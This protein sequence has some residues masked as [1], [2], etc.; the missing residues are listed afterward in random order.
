MEFRASNF[1]LARVIVLLMVAAIFVLALAFSIVFFI[2][3]NRAEQSAL[4]NSVQIKADY[5]GELILPTLMF[6]DRLAAEESISLAKSDDLLY[7]VL[8]EDAKGRKFAEFDRPNQGDRS[9]NPVK[10]VKLLF[11]GEQYLGSITVYHSN[12]IAGTLFKRYSTLLAIMTIVGVVV[13]LLLVWFVQHYIGGA[14]VQ[15]VSLTNTITVGE[16]FGKRL[17]VAGF[18]EIESLNDAL[19]KMLDALQL[20]DKKLSAQT[21]ELDVRANFDELTK[22]PNRYKLYE[23]LDGLL[24]EAKNSKQKLA[25]LS[26]DL[27][28][29]KLVNDSLGHQA[30]D[31]LLTIIAERVTKVLFKKHVFARWGGDEFVIAVPHLKNRLEAEELARAVIEAMSQPMKIQSHPIQVTAS[32]GIA[33]YPDHANNREALLSCAD[34]GMYTSKNAGAN[35]FSVYEEKAAVAASRLDIEN[36]LRVAVAKGLFEVRYQP[37][38]NAQTKTIVGLE[39][40]TRW[41]DKQLGVVQPSAFI[42]IAEELG[43]IHELTNI[44]LKQVAKDFDVWSSKGLQTVPVSVNISPSTILLPRFQTHLATALGNSCLGWTDLVLEVTEEVALQRSDDV[45]RA[46]QTLMDKGVNIALDDFGTRFSTLEHLAQLPVNI[47]KIDGVFVRSM[48]DKFGRNIRIIQSIIDLAHQLGLSVTAECV[49]TEEQLVQLREMGCDRVQ[50][51]LFYPALRP[52]ECD[53]LL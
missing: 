31:Q 27:D 46:L 18:K 51:Y 15:L 39:A 48:D 32:V 36:R 19:N 11:D 2:S 13:A 1:S 5:I 42:P 40:L 45:I 3:D 24:A 17:N 52:H 47:L 9:T 49:E 16:N 35:R 10:V 50:G 28:R 21:R 20:R 37:L 8:V 29:F 38:L 22:L 23:T 4:R 26:I 7:R 44:V 30:G 14:I 33:V 43:L 53:L 6:S 12:V 41:T 25:V 34:V